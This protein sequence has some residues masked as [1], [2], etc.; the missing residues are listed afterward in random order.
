ML[1]LIQWYLSVRK[2]LLDIERKS[3]DALLLYEQGGKE[4]AAQVNSYLKSDYKRLEELWG[5]RFQSPVPSHLGRHIAFG[6][7]GN[8]Q[9]ILTHDALEVEAKAEEALIAAAKEQGPLGFENLLHPRIEKSSYK[10]YCD[11]HLR[12][13]VMNAITAV[14]DHIREVTKILLDGSTLADKVFSPSDPYLVLSEIDTESGKNDQKGFLQIFKGA[15]LGI[16]NPKAHTLVH[17]ITPPEAAQY[18][19]FASLLARRIDAARIAKTEKG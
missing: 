12:E 2:L 8:Y 18:L 5:Q 19:V 6:M 16:R 7:D 15:F 17:D 11:G 13:A 1:Q 14:F 10:L 3:R 9:D 4:A